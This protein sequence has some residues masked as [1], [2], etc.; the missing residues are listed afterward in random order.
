MLVTKNA[1]ELS[2]LLVNELYGQLPSRIYAALLSKGRSHVGQL[3]QHTS[4][5]PRQVRHGVAVL[6]QQSLIYYTTDHD[7]AV[8]F[9][10]ANPAAAYN[11]VRV[12]KILSMIENLYGNS[13]KQLVHDALL[14]GNTE[15]VE[16]VKHHLREQRRSEGLV[17]GGS[18]AEHDNDQ[19]HVNGDSLP[20]GHVNG[21]AASDPFTEPKDCPTS[22]EVYDILAQ[23]I[24]D[25]ILET[26]TAPMFQSPQDLK[27]SIEQEVMK[28]YPNGVRGA[29]Q[30][31]EYDLAVK[32][33]YRGVR[34]ERTTLKTRLREKTMFESNAKRRKL[35]SGKSSNGFTPIGNGH[36]LQEEPNTVIRI[37]YD[38]CLVELRNQKLVEHAGDR[39]SETTGQVYAAL[40]AALSPKI[41]RCQI[42]HDTMTEEEEASAFSEA[43]VTTEEVFEHLHESV[44]VSLG[45]GPAAEEEIDVRVAEKIRKFPPEL[46][47]GGL[48]E[49]LED[50]DEVMGSDDEDYDPSGVVLYGSSLNGNH[51]SGSGPNGHKESQ[52][53]KSRLQQMRQHLLLL[54]ESKQGFVR[55]CGIKDYGEWTVDFGPILQHLKFIELDTMIEERFGRQG[56]RLTR[57]LRDKGKIDDKTLPTMA[58]MKKADVHLKMAEMEMAGFLEVQ[59]VPR[60]NNRA[61]NRTIFFW[62]FDEQRTLRRLLD[63]TYKSMVRCLQRLEVER[64]KKQMVLSVT[65]RKD[66]QGKEK[67]KLRGDIYKDYLQF[68][69]IEEKL[70]AQVARLD[71][72]VA[73]FRDY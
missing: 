55:H 22:E 35:M 11:L 44:D 49:T 28:D 33:Q 3:A 42:D 36:M 30:T 58:L 52:P 45:I 24:A 12:G 48:R 66:V 47:G 19:E 69:E 51:K 65:E 8:S 37:N 64:R 14:L 27:T 32:Q 39:I 40:L 21:N 15:I 56:L 25:G 53:R 63:N 61:A 7:T 23:L 17:N 16:L 72:L 43:R 41:T 50:G 1:A 6:I 29:K 13:A 38:K 4:L 26:V 5:N 34:S 68:L 10:D 20:N 70:L 46:H 9:Y 60:D 31:N 18:H 54:A 59:E 71:D 67:E 62:F 57:I 2:V 73:T